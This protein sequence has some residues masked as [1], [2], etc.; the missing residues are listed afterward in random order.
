MSNTFKYIDIKKHTC[1]FFD[2]VVNIK[3]FNPSKIK[4]DENSY[5]IFLFTKLDM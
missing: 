5:K 1:N 4:I 3:N 2:D